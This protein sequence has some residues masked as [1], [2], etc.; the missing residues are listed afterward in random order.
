MQKHEE[1]MSSKKLYDRKLAEIL[2]EKERWRM[3]DRNTEQS[4][5]IEL[6]EGQLKQQ[7]QDYDDIILNLKR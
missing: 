2:S 6:L 3:S 4:K 5:L 7:A 1:L